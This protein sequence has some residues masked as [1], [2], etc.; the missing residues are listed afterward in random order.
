V[1]SLNKAS[2]S[3]SSIL[4][5]LIMESIVDSTL[6][7]ASCIHYSVG[8]VLE[9]KGLEGLS[10]K[11]CG[12][13]QSVEESEVQS[14]S[15][16]EVGFSMEIEVGVAVGDSN[17]WKS[18]GFVA[19]FAFESNLGILNVVNASFLESGA[20]HIITERSIVLIFRFDVPSS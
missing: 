14:V 2:A 18:Q 6:W 1:S 5:G 10:S 20:L 11:S 7:D 19:G 4:S 13:T 16:C 17:G 9:V 15:G 12:S 3:E 8:S